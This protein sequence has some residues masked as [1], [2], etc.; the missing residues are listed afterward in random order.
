MNIKWIMVSACV[1]MVSFGLYCYESQSSD[2][3]RK[4]IKREVV[5][6]NR[7]KKQCCSCG[8]ACR[9]PILVHDP[10]Y[11]AYDPWPY[12]G[13]GPYWPGSWNYYGFRPYMGIGFSWGC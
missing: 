2:V 10:Y 11:V 8:S 6:R 12:T 3:P 7:R 5:Q 1:G 4:R 9:N 13:S